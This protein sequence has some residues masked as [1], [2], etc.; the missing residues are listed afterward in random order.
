MLSLLEK[1]FFL[2]R[3]DLFTAMDDEDLLRLAG[4]TEDLTVGPDTTLFEQGEPGDGLYMVL[5]GE[6]GIW[7]AGREI[8]VIRTGECF[9][10]IG[11]FGPVV[12]TAGARTK[13]DCYLLRLGRP[14]FQDLFG[15]HPS[16]RLAILQQLARR[17]LAI[18]QRCD[19]SPAPSA[20][21]HDCP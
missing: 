19:P 7:L 15:R 21:A 6:V 17:R 12:R 8:N 11:I 3:L 5:D 13:T 16:L 14:A 1:L 2:K 20:G 18:E 10:E 9:G 4:V